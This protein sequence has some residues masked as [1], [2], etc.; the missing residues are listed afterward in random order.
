MT[1]RTP[2]DVS[3]ERT[4]LQWII[5]SNDLFRHVLPTYDAPAL[6][7]TAFCRTVA[8]WVY[9]WGRVET[10]KAPSGALA[11]LYQMHLAEIPDEKESQA[12]GDFL[13][14]LSADWSKAEPPSVNFAKERCDLYFRR[15]VIQRSLDMATRALESG[16]DDG[17]KQAENAFLQF[18]KP[19]GT[20]APMVD[21][22]HDAQA[23]MDAYTSEDEII[24]RM[25]GTIHELLGPIIRGD[26]VGILA[27]QKR[28]KSFW[29]DLFAISAM[30]QG[31]KV[32]ILDFELVGKQ[33]ARR[34]WGHLVG[35]PRVDKQIQLPSFSNT[36]EIVFQERL[37]PGVRADLKAIEEFQKGVRRTS[38]GGSVRFI[39]FPTFGTTMR[40]V[41]ARIKQ[42]KTLHDWEPDLIIFD[43]LDYVEPE[44]KRQ[45]AR[46]QL[47][48]VWGHARGMAQ[49]YNCAVLSPS[50]TGRQTSK[51]EGSDHDVAGDIRKLWKVTKTVLLNQTTAEK[52]HGVMRV[53]TNTN[54]DEATVDDQVV[55]LQHL[56]I[57]RPYLDSR[58]L[59][60]VRSD[61]V[62]RPKGKSDILD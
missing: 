50:H 42:Y 41:R 34:L 24:F 2:I 14:K 48:E 20:E 40:E 23:I 36:G 37:V 59:S 3:D 12:I 30:L 22:L 56:G 27:P 53:S 29:V 11:M 1:R 5:A 58:W 49:E 38:Q 31:R 39:N 4:I 21:L 16:T 51:G 10:D 44:N 7:E 17:I 8:K 46:D 52:A 57:N 6:F 60:Q 25:P 55:V 35:R 26:F 28:G 13:Q 15:R 18:S 54:R 47:H 33:K 9:A 62:Y 32:L 43:S 19:L 61:L 45:D